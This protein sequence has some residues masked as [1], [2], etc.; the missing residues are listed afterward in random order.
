MTGINLY[1][2]RHGQT[3]LNHYRRIQG[4]A[5]SDLTDKGVMDA[6]AAGRA[7]S[8]IK[9]DQAYSS[10]TK[11]ASRTARIILKANPGDIHEPVQKMSL[12]EENF[13]YFEG[14]D[15]SQAWNMI[16]GPSGAADYSDMIKMF[17]IERTRDMIADADP[18]GEAENDQEFWAR[19]QPGMDEIVTMAQPGDNILVAAHGTL[20][21]SIVSKFSDI[22][23]TDRILNGSITKLVYEDGE[24]RVEYYNQVDNLDS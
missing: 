11:R 7:L 6:Q 13:G 14:N 17:S 8:K 5:D 19:V 10:D 23:I 1:F 18:Y 15:A 21:R 2:V 12:R 20:I 22:D 9:F 16:G 24:Y 3:H 4:W